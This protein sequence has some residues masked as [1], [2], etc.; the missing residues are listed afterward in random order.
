MSS[1]IKDVR[2]FAGDILVSV[3]D[4]LHFTNTRSV[5]DFN[6]AARKNELTTYSLVSENVSAEIYKRLT[7]GLEAQL[8]ANIQSIISNAILSDPVAAVDFVKNN[9]TNNG[10]I[11]DKLRG[12]VSD[13]SD[14]LSEGVSFDEVSFT[15]GNSLTEASVIIGG[16]DDANRKKLV[17]GKKIFDTEVK[18]AKKLQNDNI[19]K[20]KAQGA[21]AKVINDLKKTSSDSIDLVSSKQSFSSVKFDVKPEALDRQAISL[22]GHFHTVQIKYTTVAGKAD[23][24]EMTVFIRTQIIAVDASKIIEAMG[25]TKGRSMFNSYLEWRAGS[26]GFFKGFLLN[27]KEISRQVDRDTSKSMEDRILGSLLTK[28]GFTRP[29]MLGEITEL[30]NYNLIISTDDAD[31]LYR[32]NGLNLSKAA[33]LKKIFNG[34]NIL[35]LVVVDEVKGRAIFYES[36]NPTSMAVIS[37]KSLA[38]TEK[39]ASLFATINRH[40]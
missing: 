28:G 10:D 38:E 36:S 21:P 15:F 4:L 17:D 34:L 26:N 35:S 22:P 13:I 16:R 14:H 23:K 7:G 1:I 40:N 25:S 29:K 27:L 3:K 19:N 31:R 18:I 9:F 24:L 2:E 39:L 33:D 20:L 32:E 8:L 11:T 5:N 30:K 6:K 37:F 12:A